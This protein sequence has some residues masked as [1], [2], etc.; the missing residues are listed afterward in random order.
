MSSSK[1]VQSDRPQATPGLRDAA[2][3][4]AERRRQTLSQL[5]EALQRGDID[6][7][8]SLAWKMVGIQ[9]EQEMYRADP[10]VH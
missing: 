3:E 4:I 7:I 2:L 6:S 8:K 5:K 1:S 9:D 10:R